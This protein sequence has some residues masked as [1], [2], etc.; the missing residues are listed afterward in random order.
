MANLIA[1]RKQ[2]T[3]EIL[4]GRFIRRVL[5]DVSKDMDQAQRAKMSGFNSNFW[6][7]R[8]F[9]VTDSVLEYKHLKQHRYVDMR[10]RATKDGTK[11]KK[12]SHPIHN[13]IIMGHYNEIIKHLKYGF[14]DAVKLTLTKNA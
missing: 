12:K 6:N 4:Q 13:R 3:E 11:K 5:T 10:T 7:N 9:T 14:T 1:Q 2:N 8:S